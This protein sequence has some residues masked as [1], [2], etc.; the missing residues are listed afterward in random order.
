MAVTQRPHQDEESLVKTGTRQKKPDLYK[1]IIHN[2]HYTT[3]DFV[4]NILMQIFH[5]PAAEATQIMLKVHRQGNGI[6]GVYTFDIARTKVD[7]VNQ[8]ARQA[9]FPLKCSFEKE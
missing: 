4:V 3:M 2:D 8:L 9:Q 6:A 1:V 7:Q 5:R